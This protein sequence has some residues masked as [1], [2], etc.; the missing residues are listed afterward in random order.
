[1]ELDSQV[2]SELFVLFFNL[3]KKNYTKLV[4]ISVF[5]TLELDQYMIYIIFSKIKRTIIF[6][7]NFI[8]WFD[9]SIMKSASI[10]LFM[11]FEEIKLTEIEGIFK[12]KKEF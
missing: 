8:I 2:D 4:Y 11:E 6:F 9:K 12:T 3:I 10:E 5:D 1:M 7:N